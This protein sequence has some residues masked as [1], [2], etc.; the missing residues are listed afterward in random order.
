M[1]N[2]LAAG[3]TQCPVMISTVIA[4]YSA[5]NGFRDISHPFIIQHCFLSCNVGCW[6]VLLFWCCLV[7]YGRASAIPYSN[8]ACSL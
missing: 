6:Q 4:C 3:Q 5:N 1:S 2:Y 7:S 8:R